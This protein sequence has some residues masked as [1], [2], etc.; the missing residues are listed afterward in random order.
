MG[1]LS[2][3]IA[4]ASR[5]LGTL[6]EL[7]RKPELTAIRSRTRRVPSARLVVRFEDH[8]ASRRRFAR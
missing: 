2:E 1:R 7:V 4:V 3:R 6:D 8:A 5:A